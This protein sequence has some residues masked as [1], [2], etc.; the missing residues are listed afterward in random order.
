MVLRIYLF[1][2]YLIFFISAGLVVSILFNINPNES[3]FWMLIIFY[4]TFFIFWSAFFALVGFYLKV[5]ATN[6]EVIFAHLVPTLRQS[7][8]VGL[9]FSGLLFLQQLRVLSWWVGSL[10]V[11][12][13]IMIELFFRTKKPLSSWS[14]L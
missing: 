5:W 14:K 2:L 7:M 8:L 11:L 1:T 3:P 6:R 12:G 9:T 10:F 4:F 13:V